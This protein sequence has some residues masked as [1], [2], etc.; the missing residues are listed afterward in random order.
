MKKQL[1]LLGVLVSFRSR[2]AL[3][4]T[5]DARHNSWERHRFISDRIIDIEHGI[6]RGFFFTVP[7]VFRC[8]SGNIPRTQ[9]EL[10]TDAR[11]G[12]NSFSERNIALIDVSSSGK[13]AFSHRHRLD[14][15][16][17]SCSSL[18]TVA[19]DS[20]P[21][22]AGSERGIFRSRLVIFS[23]RLC[24]QGSVWYMSLF[25]FLTLSYSTDRESR[26]YT[27]TASSKLV[28]LIEQRD[29]V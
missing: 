7:E 1:E 27:L 3:M 21:R 16:S 12:F 14:R 22:S 17:L 20:V 24:L 5:S 15:V 28:W 23:I 9:L 25:A 8:G 18:F 13:R 2:K 26:R 19:V 10:G 6:L 29:S 11:N 4:T